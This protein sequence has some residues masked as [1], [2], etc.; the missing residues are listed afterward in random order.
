MHIDWSEAVRQAQDCIPG[1]IEVSENV[2]KD[3]KRR[4]CGLHLM[5][6]SRNKLV[7]LR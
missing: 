4:V 1:S 7:S 3:L 5:D 6:T 2:K